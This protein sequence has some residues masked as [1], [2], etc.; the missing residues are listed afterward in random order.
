MNKKMQYKVPNETHLK[1][2]WLVQ[3]LASDFELLDVW[4]CPICFKTDEGDTL[5]K[6]R[7][8]AIEPTLKN[9]FNFSIAGA[10]FHFRGIIG[11]IFRLDKDL[12]KLPIPGCKEIS[13]AERM[14]ETEKSQHSSKLDI[15]IR[16]GNFFDFKTVY[17]FQKETV[18]EIS[19]ATEHAL[20]HYA[21][22]KG[23]NDCYK[24]QMAIY[25]KHRNRMGSFYIK[26]ISPFRHWIVYPYL[27]T[28][29]VRRWNEHKTTST[30]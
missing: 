15:D 3:K 4:E 20:M 6:F 7:K 22:V 27:F 10:L 2:D 24:V 13:L 1:N 28:E 25:I 8:Y 9:A 26:L 21:W 14:S 19:T 23:E 5:Y 18:N 29:Y 17:S 30:S 11:K 12:N 16:A